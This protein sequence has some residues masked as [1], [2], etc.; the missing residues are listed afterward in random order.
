MDITYCGKCGKK[1]IGGYCADCG[2]N[3][4]ITKSD[5]QFFGFPILKIPLSF[6]VANPLYG[7]YIFRADH[8]MHSI[9]LD[10]DM[11][12][13]N[14]Q[15]IF[16][17]I[18]KDIEYLN[19]RIVECYKLY[20]TG[21][22]YNG[23][24]GHQ[25]TVEEI[26]YWMRRITDRLISIHWI[27]AEFENNGVYPDK[28]EIDSIGRLFK[29]AEGHP[30]KDEYDDNDVAFLSFLNEASNAYKHSLINGESPSL[31][32]GKEEPLVITLGLRNNSIFSKQ[33]YNHR[34]LSEAVLMFTSFYKGMREKLKKHN[35]FQKEVVAI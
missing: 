9:N 16:L 23:V 24:L 20:A 15:L 29:L 13:G 18:I 7:T 19:S 26:I 34:S 30:F 8:I 1:L 31:R 11:T 10:S 33:E 27:L 6:D 17:N 35:N 21:M 3:T 28:I 25:K 5:F 2:I 4:L 32:I 12:F 14:L 22:Y